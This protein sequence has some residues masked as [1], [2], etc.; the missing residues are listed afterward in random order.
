MQQQVGSALLETVLVVM[1]RPLQNAIQKHNILGNHSL[2]QLTLKAQQW[3]LT[4]VSPHTSHSG[5]WAF[6]RAMLERKIGVVVVGF[7]ATPIGEA[8]A[9]F[10]VSAAHTKDM[11][12]KVLCALDELG[13]SLVLK[14]SRQTPSPRPELC[15]EADFELDS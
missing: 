6:S 1:K 9:R 12:D 2:S 14:F 5:H 13:D 8:R 7:P 15:N 11:L 3:E 10:C 4:P